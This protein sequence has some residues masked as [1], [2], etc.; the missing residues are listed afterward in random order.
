MHT[1]PSYPPPDGRAVVDFV[2]ENPFAVVVSPAPEGPPVATHLPMILPPETDPGESLAGVTMYG[3]MGR[4]NPHWRLFRERADVLMVFSSSHGYVSPSLYGFAPTAPT[5]DYAAVHLT[6]EATLI[7]D[8]AA[9]LEVVERTVSALESM[10]PAQ[11]DPEPS[12]ELFERIIGKVAA[13]SV[14]VTGQQAMFKLSQDMPED[15]RGRVRD[16]FDRGPHRHPGLV[17]LMDHMEEA[18][19]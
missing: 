18:R 8:A 2:R 16:D 14:R 11:W 10:R 6:G 19:R 4:A 5:L 9:A 1:Y 13:F 17:R 12:R 7:E 3:H 15:V